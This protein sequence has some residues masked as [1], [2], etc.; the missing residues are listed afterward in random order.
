MSILKPH[1]SRY[2]NG[3]RCLI[4]RYTSYEPKYWKHLLRSHL[5]P[6]SRRI[7]WQYQPL[8]IEPLPWCLS[9]MVRSYVYPRIYFCR[10]CDDCHRAKPV[11]RSQEKIEDR[12]EFEQVEHLRFP[13]CLKSGKLQKWI[14]P[15]NRMSRV[16]GRRH[17]VIIPWKMLF[18][19]VVC[20]FVWQSIYNCG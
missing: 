11:V 12:K 20:G 10:I 2:W 19:P 17:P 1:E 6:E 16:W 8:D 15:V 7:P 3:V 9:N 18:V 14:R 13:C 5:N 4:C